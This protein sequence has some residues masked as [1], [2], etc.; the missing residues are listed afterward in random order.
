MINAERNRNKCVQGELQAA[1]QDITKAAYH[2][3]NL[4]SQGG[5]QEHPEITRQRNLIRNG[6]GHDDP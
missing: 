2:Y 6:T 1:K 3:S 5:Q 4:N